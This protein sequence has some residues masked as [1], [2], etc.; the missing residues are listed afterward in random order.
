MKKSEDVHIWRYPKCQEKTIHDA[1][2][3][4][5]VGENSTLQSVTKAIE[6]TKSKLAKVMKDLLDQLI[7]WFD[8]FGMEI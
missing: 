4:C 3:E 5:G 7:L 6:E 8:C 2:D 1:A